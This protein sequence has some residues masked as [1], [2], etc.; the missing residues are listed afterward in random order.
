M[1]LRLSACF[2]DDKALLVVGISAVTLL[3]KIDKKSVTF[4]CT[5][6]RNVICLT[7]HQYS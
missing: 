3:A 6:E 5:A 7:R 2:D 4:E 1:G